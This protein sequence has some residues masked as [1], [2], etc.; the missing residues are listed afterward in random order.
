MDKRN[1]ILMSFWINRAAKR[2]FAIAC[3]VNNSSMTAEINR[4]IRSYIA[5]NR[6]KV[7]ERT[8]MFGDVID[9]R[10]FGVDNAERDSGW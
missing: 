10:F 6:A 4:H 3:K 2:D 7:D 5:A 8:D 1:N 9:S